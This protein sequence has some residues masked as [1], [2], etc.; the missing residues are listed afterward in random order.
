MRVNA[1]ARLSS[2]KPLTFRSTARM[3]RL[4]FCATSRPGKAKRSDAI[5]SPLATARTALAD[6]RCLPGKSGPSKGY[7]R[8][9]VLST[10][11]GI[12][13]H[14]VGRRSMPAGEVRTFERVYPFGWLGILA[15]VPPCSHE[16]IYARHRRGFALASMRSMSRSRYYL[17]CAIDEKLEDWPD[18]RIWEELKIRLG[19]A[20]AAHMKVG[21]SIEKSIAP[22]RSF[23]A[24]PMG[25]GRLFLAGDAAHIVP[26]TGAKGL[27]LAVSD[28]RILSRAFIAYFKKG[29]R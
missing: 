3:G 12:G 7:T 22:L 4:R 14:G 17:Q 8:S 16:L 28:V 1:P 5:S 23:V 9:K 13:A 6:A 26:P 15:E 21:P 27:N 10:P 29:D 2:M 11:A 24:E 18:E 19:P 20:A 25:W